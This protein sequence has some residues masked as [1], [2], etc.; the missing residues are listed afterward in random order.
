MKK[1]I[2]FIAVL[3]LLISSTAQGKIYNSPDEI[4]PDLIKE[5][6]LASSSSS[7]E[8]KKSSSWWKWG[9][10][11]LAVGAIG[12]AAGGGGGGGSSSPAAPAAADTGSA[13]V[14]W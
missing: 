8:A 14:N 1:T 12:A 3:M 11:L 4:E 7:T 9:L 10:G 5:E 2:T 13:T 6:V